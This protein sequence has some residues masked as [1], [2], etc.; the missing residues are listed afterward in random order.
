MDDWIELKLGEVANFVLGQAPAGTE[1]NKQGEGTLF[2]K[3]GEFGALYPVERE[4]TTNPLSLGKTGDVFICIVGATVG[5]LNL[6][7]DCAIGRSV[8]A[9]RPAEG[10]QPKFIYYQLLRKVLELRAGSQG[11]AQGVL[12]RGDLYSIPFLLASGSAQSRTCL[13]LEEMFSDIDAGVAALERTRGNLRRYRAAVL[14]AAVEG[15]LTERW[16]KKHPDV[17][18][19]S[20]LLERILVERRKKWEEDQLSKCAAAGKVMPKD[21]KGKYP[22]PA[23]VESGRLPELPRGW[24]WTTLDTLIISGPQNGLYMPQSAYGTGVPILRIDDFQNDWSRGSSELR[25]VKAST[26]DVSRYALRPGDIVVNR[27]NSPSHLGK[28]LVIEDRHVPTLFES[29]MMRMGC[30]EHCSP[31]YV[32][33]Y[34]R[35]VNGKQ[36]LIAN[37]KWAVNQAS[38]NQRD[39]SVTPVAVPPLA[40]QLE[41]VS[42]VTQA[43]SSQVR[44]EVEFDGAVARASHLRQSILKRAFEGKLVPQ[45]PN[46]EPASVLLE[47]IRAARAAESKSPGTKSRRKSVA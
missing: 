44:A 5:K 28:C 40:E 12:T 42:A 1:C 19:A 22:K 7:I 3:A 6:G 15:R 39:V 29:N 13:K 2:V 10:V 43:L 14:K 17:E 32:V 30:S 38:I 16:R 35:S 11:S 46:D 37:A 4:W 20:K 47:R 24:C 27:V 25:M 26:D 31:H 45:D 21:W 41:I 23:V 8:A 33:A 9:I 18:P 36:R 34:L